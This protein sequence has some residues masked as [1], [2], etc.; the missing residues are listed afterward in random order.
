MR[1]AGP[2]IFLLGAGASKDAGMLLLSELTAELASRLSCLH[3]FSGNVRPDF[4]ELFDAIAACDPLVSKNYEKFF[5]WLRLVVT[6]QRKPYKQLLA[7]KFA[8]RLAKAARDLEFVINR[9]F[10]DVFDELRKSWKYNPQYFSRLKD[11]IPNGGRLKVFS[12]NYDLTVEDACRSAGIPF[13]T[14]FNNEWSPSHFEM[15]GEALNIYKLH[16]SLSWFVKEELSPAQLFERNPDDFDQLPQLILGPGAKFQYDD[17][18]VTLYSEFHRAIGRAKACV[19]VGCSL[20]DD[21][22]REPLRAA[23]KRGMTVVDVRPGDDRH[24]CF[25]HYKKI[26]FGAKEAFENDKIVA[27]LGT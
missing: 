14:G 2:V 23:S 3:D 11:F 1:H 12:L 9:P 21:H 19:V 17:P 25:T 4:K 7:L 16:G 15:P 13:T 5:E 8:S 26:T 6:A 27:A 10:C 24:T 20:N 18:F 22:I